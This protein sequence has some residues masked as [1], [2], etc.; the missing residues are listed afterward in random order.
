MTPHEI[1]LNH[2]NKLE[3]LNKVTP[4]NYAEHITKNREDNY[5]FIGSN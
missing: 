4:S 2:K 1:V 5:Q 3:V